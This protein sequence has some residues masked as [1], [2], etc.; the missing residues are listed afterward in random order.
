MYIAVQSASTVSQIMSN[1]LARIERETV[2]ALCTALA[3]TP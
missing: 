2:H 1:S 3:V